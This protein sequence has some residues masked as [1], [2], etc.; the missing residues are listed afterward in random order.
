MPPFEFHKA[1]NI[2]H[3][4]PG[5]EKQEQHAGD[6]RELGNWATIMHALSFAQDSY[7]NSFTVRCWEC[8]PRH[9]DDILHDALVQFRNQFG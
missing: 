3:Q 8:D 5:C 6:R 2:V 4:T 1:E 7:G 9:R